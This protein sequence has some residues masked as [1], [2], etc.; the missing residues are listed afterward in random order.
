MS[1]TVTINFIE[2][3]PAPANGY[4]LK[5][6]VAGTSDPYTDEGNFSFSP[7][8]FVD[9]INPQGTC[10]EGFL[11]SDCSQSGDSVTLLGEAI[12]WATVC[13]ESGVFSHTIRLLIPCAGIPSSF[14]I[15]NGTVG[16]V[17]TVRATFAGMIQKTSNLFTRANLT[18][19]SP[20]GTSD[21]NASACYSDTGFHG[22]SITADSTI[23]MVGT[24]TFV[25]TSAVTHNSS[26]S[27]SSLTVTII[28]INGTPVDIPISGCKGDSSTGGTC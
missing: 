4:N 27:M 8:S 3:E 12:P 5:W 19:S 13:G 21:A 17:L 23:T 10:Y 11:Q 16:D 14:I 25:N 26:A 15:E 22:F 28:D 6:R 1:N 7:A 20:D 18:I 24:T 9:N 2:C